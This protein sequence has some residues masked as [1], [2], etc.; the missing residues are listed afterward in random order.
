[1]KQKVMKF[2][3]ALAVLIVMVLA[4]GIM[5]QRE[6]ERRYQDAQRRLPELGF[7]ITAEPRR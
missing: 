5:Q 2:G 7:I 3:A 4:G 1:M 6:H